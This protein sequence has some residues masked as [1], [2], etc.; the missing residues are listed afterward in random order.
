V[1]IKSNIALKVCLAFIL[2]LA[3]LALFGCTGVRSSP[4][5][6]SGGV[7]ADGTLFLCPGIKGGGGGFGCT[8]PLLE[9]KLV[10]VNISD[11]NRLWEVA[12]EASGSSGGGFGCAPSAIP[13]AIYGNPAVAGD[14]VYIAGYNGRIYAISASTRLSQDKYVNETNPQ[15]IIGGPVVVED[16]VYLAS[17]DGMVYALNAASLEKEWEF[18]TGGKLWSTPAIEGDT[19]YIG[20]FDKKLYALNTGDGTQKWA[21]ETEGAIISTPLVYDNTVYIGSFDR[22][23]YAV[24]ATTGKRIWRFPAT[25]EDEN[26]PGSWFWAKAVVY[27]G[28]VYAP[29]LDGKVYILNAGTGSEVVDAVDLG[30]PI[31]SSP[32]LVGSSVIIASEEG[33]IFALDTSNNQLK[34]LADL[35]EAIYAPLCAAGEGSCPC[36]WVVYVY[37]G[38]QNLYALDAESGATLWTLSVK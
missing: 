9:G 26:K 16:R 11:G 22:Y 25:D 12:L 19:L 36:S 37:T 21:F 35:G 29:C 30:S 23:L 4:E 28:T 20:S 10:A 18:P 15:P 14:L 27:E 5:G 38:S 32:V 6:G 17:A 3:G 13:V 24:D 33:K 1:E 31:S 34:L 7:V 8:P 2:L